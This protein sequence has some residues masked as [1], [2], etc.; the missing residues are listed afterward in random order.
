M[1]VFRS[2]RKAL[3]PVDAAWYRMDSA[4]S[5]A[6]IAGLF[7][8]DG[9]VDESALRQRVAARLYI[10]PRFQQRVVE[11]KLHVRSPRWEAEP[12]G[13]FDQH[14][15]KRSLPAP[16]GPAE[17]HALVNELMNE[18]IDFRFSPWRMC[19][20]EGYSAGAV[21]F[22]QLHHCMADGFA[23]VELLL[24]MA[25][26]PIEPAAVPHHPKA[27]RAFSRI[28]R[29]VL[30][31]AHLLTMPFD[32]STRFRGKLS[33]RRRVAWSA[34]IALERAR[35][36]AHARSST[37]NDVL[38][39]VLSGAL[40]SYVLERGDEPRGFRAVMPVNLRTQPTAA[41]DQ[42][43]GNW[44]GLVFV[45][46][47]LAAAAPESRL[48]ELKRSVDR[49]KHSEEP[50]A[51]LVV[52]TLLGRVPQLVESAFK[53]LFARK[54]TIVVSNVIGPRH[55]FQM[56]GKRVREMMFWVPHPSGLSCGI[57]MLSYDGAVRVGVR[58]DDAL[59][60]DPERL[61][62]LFERELAAWEAA[63]VIQC[64]VPELRRL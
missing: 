18:P 5:P 27:A 23:L 15:R 53:L 11:P 51:S 56:L 1:P 44:F 52:L 12:V 39:A 62:Q 57:S 63:N 24:S 3:A 48:Q 34:P 58:S 2:R 43:S 17:L 41:I 35:N 6:D 20:I 59:V 31:L 32:A 54:G 21:V 10:H 8:L 33:G 22:C 45:D 36:L 61:T 28:P 7:M 64:N 9:P 26:E 16:G 42:H 29:T 40:R 25:D 46:L 38:M 13:S 60:P 19:L 14:F 47:P 30:S 55:A 37:I 49:I 50:L 4:G